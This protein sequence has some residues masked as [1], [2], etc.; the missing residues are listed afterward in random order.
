MTP[1]PSVAEGFAIRIRVDS[2][3]VLKCDNTHRICDN[4]AQSVAQDVG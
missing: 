4:S 1:K 3:S 2:E